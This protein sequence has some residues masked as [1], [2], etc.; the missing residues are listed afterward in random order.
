MVGRP[1]NQ[2]RLDAIE[3]G[4]L[5]YEGMPHRN[6]GKTLRYCSGGGCVHC[7]RV[8]ATEQREARKYLKSRAT[9]ID[10]RGDQGGGYPSSQDFAE[11]DPDP[12]DIE[13]DDGLEA[14]DPDARTQAG[15]DE[16]M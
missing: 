16:L 2:A 1:I 4:L 5:T 3:L 14:D 13:P 6:C 7:A 12:V 11:I 10:S 15:I 9:Q 8:I